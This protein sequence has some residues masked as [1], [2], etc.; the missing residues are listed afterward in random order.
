MRREGYIVVPFDHRLLPDTV[1]RA[2]ERRAQAVIS[3]V[4]QRQALTLTPLSFSIHPQLRGNR[5]PAK[6]IRA[7]FS[8]D[9]NGRVRIIVSDE[10]IAAT[11][12]AGP[13][14]KTD[15]LVT[16]TDVGS[17][18]T[19]LRRGLVGVSS[20]HMNVSG[21]QIERAMED[22][23]I[24]IALGTFFRELG[25]LKE[26]VQRGGLPTLFQEKAKFFGMN[27]SRSW[28][29]QAD[30]DLS[31]A[32]LAS[33]NRLPADDVA[34]RAASAYETWLEFSRSLSAARLTSGVELDAPTRGLSPDKDQSDPT[35]RIEAAG[36]LAA[37][38]ASM[39]KLGGQLPIRRIVAAVDHLPPG[40]YSI[41]V[42]LKSSSA[43]KSPSFRGKMTALF[44]IRARRNSF[45]ILSNERFLS[46]RDMI[47][48]LSRSGHVFV[49]KLRLRGTTLSKD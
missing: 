9:F 34:G 38:L 12:L 40:E 24:D 22:V 41:I 32:M 19:R 6:Y 25:P 45:R 27:L 33:L 7:L 23:I 11:S 3:A 39:P 13:F 42:L 31:Y 37:S 17:S 35:V 18:T 21:P 15:L 46:T 2:I 49:A 4:E 28:I 5:T 1:A 14:A 16:I 8:G 20:C 48:E 30:G 36:D 47:E 44:G 29:T 10:P 43:R 26:L